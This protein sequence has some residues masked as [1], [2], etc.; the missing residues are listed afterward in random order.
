MDHIADNAHQDSTAKIVPIG[1]PKVV[2][3]N[4]N[5]KMEVAPVVKRAFITYH[6]V[7]C[8]VI[9]LSLIANLVLILH[10]VNNVIWDDMVPPVHTNVLISVKYALISHPA[11]SVAL[12][13]MDHYV[14]RN[15][16]F[17][18]HR[19]R[20]ILFVTIVLQTEKDQR[21]AVANTVWG[22]VQKMV[23]APEIAQ[24]G[25]LGLTVYKSVQIVAN[26]ALRL[27]ITAPN[28]F[29]EFHLVALVSTCS[30][31]NSSYAKA[32]IS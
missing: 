6:H 23:R 18:V 22:I 17:S 20:T 31:F 12:V 11:C 28:A 14:V 2:D 30:F 4:V 32:F 10:I 1:V 19:A 7:I 27:L 13:I 9:L 16:L 25:G 24:T 8:V 21:V 3:L 26:T 5:L 15:A 29:M